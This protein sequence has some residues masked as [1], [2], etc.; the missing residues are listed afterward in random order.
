MIKEAI[1]DLS[2][3][4]DLSFETSKEVMNEI[5]SGNATDV[6]ISAYL[7]G[8]VVKGET[9]DEI[10]GSAVAMREHSLKLSHNLNALEIVGTGGDHSN[11]FNIS[12][13]SA[14]VV[15]SAD[16]P[17]AKHGN[18]ASSS[19]C[20]SADVLEDLGVK[21]DIPVEKSA[22]LLEEIGICFLFAQ[23]YHSSMKYVA[24]VRRELSIRTIFNILGPL[25]N[26]ASANMQVMGVYDESLVKPLAQVLL[27][28]GVKN[29]MVVYGKDRLDEI[30][31]CD[32][33]VVCEI[34][35]GEFRDYEICPEDFG[36][37]TVDKSELLGG[38]PEDNAKITLAILNGEKSARRDAVCLNAGAGLYVAKKAKTLADGVL[39]AEKLLDDKKALNKLQEFIKYSNE[40]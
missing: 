7:T 3:K 26:P 15:A 37:K 10:T 16:V 30:S 12:T 20:G 28:L 11:S 18:R 40:E 32:K 25:S 23:R 36:Y 13:T 2:L 24:G 6:Q 39:M 17:I 38:D 4:K 1:I 9:I 34:L 8:L 27:N 29:A 5:M 35:D 31:M 33:T 21:I 22:K 19:K 14:I